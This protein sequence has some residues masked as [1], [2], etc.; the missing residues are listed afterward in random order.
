ML[1]HVSAVLSVR[2][3]CNSM[4]NSPS[5]RYTEDYPVFIDLQDQLQYNDNSLMKISIISGA[6]YRVIRM[7]LYI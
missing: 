3:G 2:K 7:Y 4:T 6:G 1:L 5:A